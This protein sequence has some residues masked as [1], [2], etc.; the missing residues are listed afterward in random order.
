[1]RERTGWDVAVVGGGPA[2]LTAASVAAAAGAR[3]LVLERA[4]HPR[5]KTCGG[6]LIGAS[7]AAV[8]SQVTVPARDQIRSATFTLR[9]AQELTSSDPE[10][11]LAMVTREE[12]DA[13]LADRAQ[14]Q[15][16][17]LRQQALVRAV[18]Q[19]AEGASARLADGSAVTAKVVIGAD[20]SSGVTAR[21]V[22]AEFAQVDLGLELE[23]AVPP[24]AARPWAGRVLL[25]WG[26]LPAS[27]G[28]VFPKGDRLTVGVIAARGH[29]EYTRSYL[30]EF[31]ERLGLG[32]FEVV[33][34]SG[35]LT[36]CRTEGSPLR[37]GRVLVAGD[38][39]GLLDPWTREGISF[40][41]RSG[42][43]AGEAA[44]KA[45]VA[46]SPEEATASLDG[47][48]AA[49]DAT[50]VPEMRLGRELLSAFAR[51]PGTFH[52]TLNTPKGWR[53][54]VRMC[55][56]EISFTHLIN[57]PSARLA[58]AMLNRV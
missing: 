10:P 5:Y 54:F 47:Y 30:R 49:L 22:G 34:D 44:A 8:G 19:A 42:A 12:F 48:A 2:G 18:D 17:V 39:A 28:W 53:I 15:G 52:R 41:L 4:E 36:R 13:A 1:V 14:Q 38:A 58:L 6:G 9:G 56:S 43:L 31:V 20:G 21:H 25:D 45:A 23:I 27:Y 46:G 37:R 33:K 51:H 29:G 26:K 40:A 57:R 32:S 35:H 3:T 7:I 24:A 11:L 16:A 55:R 50:L